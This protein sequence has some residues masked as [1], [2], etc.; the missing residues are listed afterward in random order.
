MFSKFGIGFNRDILIHKYKARPVIYTD[1]TEFV[2][3]HSS[4]RW[5]CC[6]FDEENDFTW[7]REWRIEGETFD[8]SKVADND[9]IIIAPTEADLE[10]LVIEYELKG[11]DYSILENVA[12]PNPIYRTVRTKKGISFEKVSS[13]HNDYELEASLYFNQPTEETIEEEKT[14]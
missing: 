14:R 1:R 6:L 4:L 10:P 13:Y 12:Y 2:K 11:M 9:M 5:R 3:I 7:Q 8:F